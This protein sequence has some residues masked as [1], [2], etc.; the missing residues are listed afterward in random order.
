[1]LATISPW[2]WVA[3]GV[4]LAALEMVTPTTVTIWSAAAALVVALALWLVP[5]MGVAAQIAVFGLLSIAFT[6]GG[7]ALAA[8]YLPSGREV[9]L[10]R[11]TGAIVGRTGRVLSFSD[12]EGKVEID[13]VPWPARLQGAGA[14]A[15]G[16]RVTVVGADGIVVLVEPVR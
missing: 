8:R 16:D 12:G 2:W 4:L 13:G 1:M 14:P 11:R 5:G 6:F 15:P 7:R 10:N 3:L 9:T